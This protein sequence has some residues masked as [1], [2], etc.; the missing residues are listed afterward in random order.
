MVECSRS[1]SGG[2]DHRGRACPAGF[3]LRS[4]ERRA[5]SM[6]KRFKTYQTS[7]SFFELAVAAPSMKGSAK[8]CQTLQH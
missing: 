8:P 7:S 3:G 6:A 4:V 1:L 5:V 2:M